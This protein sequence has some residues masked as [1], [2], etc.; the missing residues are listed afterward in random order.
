MTARQPFDPVV[1]IVN[2]L[3]KWAWH[4]VIDLIGAW[5]AQLV[6]R[7]LAWPSLVLQFYAISRD[8]AWSLV[9]ILMVIAILRSVWPQFSWVGSRFSVP[10]FLER[11]V[12]A[13]FMGLIGAWAVSA[14]LH[15]NNAV[16]ES[17]T[18]GAASWQPTAAPQGVLSPVVVLLVSGAML[19]LILYLALF[20]AVRAIELYLLTAAIP[21]FVLWWASR[22][23]DVVLSTLGKELGVV[24]FIQSF[25]AG[26][27]WLT[28]RLLTQ[29]QLGITGFFMELAL[30][31]YMTKLPGQL[32]RLVGNSAGVI[33]LWR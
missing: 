9:G 21:W 14:A 17:L 15:I 25:H 5:M 4:Q 8:L 12:A 6:F 32:R 2:E 30:L 23:D 28:T 16:V 10:F 19:L 22:D 18:Q 20:Y 13:G 27:F 7:P 33:R 29:S 31:W 24:I 11:L 3:S 1:S 26:A